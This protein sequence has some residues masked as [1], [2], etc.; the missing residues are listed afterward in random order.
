MKPPVLNTFRIYSVF[1]NTQNILDFVAYIK[2][3]MAVRKFYMILITVYHIWKS[4]L[5]R[6]PSPFRVNITRPSKYA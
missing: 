3:Q 6:F 1:L 5:D 4:V 2:L